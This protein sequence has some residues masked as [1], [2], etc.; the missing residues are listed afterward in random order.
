[1][2]ILSGSLRGRNYYM[3]A[4]IQPTQNIMRKALFD[5]LGHDLKGLHLLELY[6]GSGAVGIEAI[7]LGAKTVTFV[8]KDPRCYRVIQENLDLLKIPL[9]R[10]RVAQYH[11]INADALPTI[12]RF[13][14]EGKKFDWVFFDPPYGLDLAKKTL[15]TL[16][17]HDILQPVC[18]VIAQH[19]GAEKLPSESGR[20]TLLSKRAYGKSFLTIYVGKP[21]Q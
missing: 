18:F 12:K 9:V 7:S 2:R 16:S 11:L 6:A 20:F 13:E 15:N 21:S 3:P 4:Q 1:M 5:I 10:D 19:D 14:R 8:E 17:T